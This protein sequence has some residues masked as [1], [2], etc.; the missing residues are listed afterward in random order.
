[1]NEPVKNM[2]IILRVNGEAV[3]AE[4][5]VRRNLV[6]FLRG[7]L[8]LTGSHVG[9]EHGVC[10]ACTVVVDGA[11][12]RGCL[13]L[14]VQAD[15]CDIETIEGADESG[16]IAALQAAFHRRNALQCGFCTPAML[17][18]AAALLAQNGNPT[19]DEIRECLSGNFCRCTGYQAIVDA[20]A[21]VAEVVEA[22]A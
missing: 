1:M 18:T 22:K 11:I 5:P 19:R 6:D 7:D 16:R 4:V 20:V 2:R 17:L 8:G 15:R 12:M 9:C 14:A 21:E 13:L 10:G 3:E